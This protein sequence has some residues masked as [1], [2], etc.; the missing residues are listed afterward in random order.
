MNSIARSV[1]YRRAWFGVCIVITSGCPSDS[2][3]RD[4]VEPGAEPIVLVV[5]NLYD[6]LAS[7][8]SVY[9]GGGTGLDE[10]LARVRADLSDELPSE[11]LSPA[12][13]AFGEPG[14]S[15][16]LGRFRDVGGGQV[17]VV[18]SFVTVDSS[19][20]G[21]LEYTLESAGNGWQISEVADAWPD[22]SVSALREDSYHGALERARGDECL[23]LG[24]GIGTCGPWLYVIESTGFTGTSSYY[25]WQTGLLAAREQFSDA[26][27]VS[28]LFVFGHVDCEP[29]ITETIPCDR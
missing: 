16:A 28:D 27:E 9:L 2:A 5:E 12:D 17:Q 6:R 14:A 15:I 29:T 18:A 1:N 10:T 22:C 13:R 26:D 24:T 11:F 19:E 7:P 23:R 25:D 21:C 3:V 20:R 4:S 8:T